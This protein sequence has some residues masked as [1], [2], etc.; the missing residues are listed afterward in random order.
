MG[1]DMTGYIEKRLDNDDRLF[2]EVISL[3]NEWDLMR[4]FELYFER[5]MQGAN[6]CYKNHKKTPFLT[7]NTALYPIPY[8]DILE[9]VE[10]IK[11]V[12]KNHDCVKEFYPGIEFDK[13]WFDNLPYIEYLIKNIIKTLKENKFRR[14][15]DCTLFLE[16]W[17]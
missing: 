12:K 7:F 5:R 4:F 10:E 2:H 6:G 9:M 11:K 8:E 14:G 13:E 15:R 1:H 3:R 16:S 17:W